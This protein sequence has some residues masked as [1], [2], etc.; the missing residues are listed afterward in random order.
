M[1]IRH[2]CFVILKALMALKFLGDFR[3]MRVGKSHTTSIA[4]KVS[5]ACIRLS[6]NDLTEKEIKGVVY[7]RI[8]SDFLEKVFDI[9]KNAHIVWLRNAT[10]AIKEAIGYTS[11]QE[12]AK[13][14]R[15][16]QYMATCDLGKLIIEIEPELL[17]E[18]PKGKLVPEAN[19]FNVT[20]KTKP[21]CHGWPPVP[22]VSIGY[23]S[24]TTGVRDFGNLSLWNVR[25]LKRKDFTRGRT[26]DEFFINDECLPTIENVITPRIK[27]HENSIFFVHNQAMAHSNTTVDIVPDTIR[28]LS[29]INLLSVARMN[30]EDYRQWYT[31]YLLRKERDAFIEG[32]IYNTVNETT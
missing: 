16:L 30:P 20:R 4:R 17:Q 9:F 15:A 26:Y 11:Q 7:P 5:T 13:A 19:C 23:N 32:K 18:K 2:F 31:E 24:D 3:Y 25:D 14:T 10:N 27:P 21:H 6:T 12:V 28:R 1:L 8:K 22:I 29:T